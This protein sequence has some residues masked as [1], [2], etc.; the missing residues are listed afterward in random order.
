MCAWG[1][2][3]EGDGCDYCHGDDCTL[4]VQAENVTVMC[5]FIL[6]INYHCKD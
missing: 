3:G 5:K 1:S 4:S 2:E 6:A